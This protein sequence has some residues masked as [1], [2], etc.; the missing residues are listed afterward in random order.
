MWENSK[1]F[2]RIGFLVARNRKQL[3]ECFKRVL[4]GRP[5]TLFSF[6][7]GRAALDDWLHQ[8][9][10]GRVTDE[11]LKCMFR[12]AVNP[13]ESQVEPRYCYERM[14][15]IYRQRFTGPQSK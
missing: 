6:V 12:V 4:G 11:Q 7:E 1:D 10:G 9:F 14:L 8:N 2:E 3:M 15:D 5:D 13:S